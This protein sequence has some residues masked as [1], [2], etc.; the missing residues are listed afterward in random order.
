[1][2]DEGYIKFRVHREHG[3][4]V[5]KQELLRCR[6]ILYRAGLIGMYPNGIG[7][8]NISQRV[9]KGNPTFWITATATGG[10]ERLSANEVVLIEKCSPQTNELWC[11][12][13]RDP[14]SESMTH[15][16]VYNTLPE[17][18]GIA[19]IH[20]KAMWK[21]LLDSLP[22]TPADVPYGTAEMA[23]AVQEL[24][25]VPQIKRAGIFAMAGHDEGIL[26]FGESPE[27]AVK[28]IMQLLEECK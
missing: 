12:G 28:N 9:Q 20:H 1:M 10:L 15:Y 25:Q 23:Q 18:M 19:H 7:F 13:T 22:S 6:Q 2:Q 27:K 17:Q 21:K 5:P 11:K 4:V 16:M 8:G 26:S 3:P 24:L 14:S